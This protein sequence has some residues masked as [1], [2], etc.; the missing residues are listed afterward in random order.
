[1]ALIAIMAIYN[2]PAPST[3]HMIETLSEEKIQ[4]CIREYWRRAERKFNER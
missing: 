4:E 2:I 3:K 1:M